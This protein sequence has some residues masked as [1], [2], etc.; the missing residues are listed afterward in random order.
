MQILY[1]KQ[2]A[3]HYNSV[4][5]SLEIVNEVFLSALGYTM[6]MYTGVGELTYSP[7]DI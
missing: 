2:V 5:N 3:P 7:S 6:L 4:F 1:Y